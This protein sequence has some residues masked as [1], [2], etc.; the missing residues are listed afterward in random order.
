MSDKGTEEASAQKKKKARE[1]G[2]FVRSR[3]LLSAVAMLCGLLTL[4]FVVHD[5]ILTWKANFERS[6]SMPMRDLSEEAVIISVKE[7]LVSSGPALGVILTSSFFGALVTGVAQSGGVNFYPKTLEWKFSK[8]NPVTNLKNLVSIR[9]SVRVAKSIVPAAVMVIIGWH[10]LRILLQSIPVMGSL[11]LSAM[12]DTAY[13]LVLDAAWVSFI[14][15]AL[16]YAA[17]WQSWNS[18]L[19]MTKQ[20]L[21]DEAKEGSGNPL[22]KSRIRQIQR[23]MRRRR[24]KAD[25]SRASVVITN[26]THYAVALLFSFETMQAPTVLAK[27][28]DLHALEI[29]EEARWAGVPLMENPALA[30]TLYRSVEPGQS[31]P[32]ELYQTVAAILAFLYRQRVEEK[33]RG[34]QR[35][36]DTTESGVHS[37]SN[38]GRLQG[39]GGGM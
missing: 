31:I 4:G 28:R 19:K 20:E 37:L 10:A 18:R 16:D 2:D 11:R 12:F 9:A 25:I 24:V 36:A 1:D 5:F 26:P 15:S 23:L 17:E 6:I 29:R 7:A 3:E 14:W 30:R 33:M 32:F 34:A 27:G 21:R 38:F 8:F 13:H 35:T 22:I 39:Y